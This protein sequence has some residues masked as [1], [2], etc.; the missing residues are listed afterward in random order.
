MSSEGD[1]LPVVRRVEA[2]YKQPQRDPRDRELSL[3]RLPPRFSRDRPR[4][5]PTSSRRRRRTRRGSSRVS[6]SPSR[7]RRRAACCGRDT[8]RCTWKVTDPDGDT[9]TYEVAFKPAGSGRWLPLRKGVRETFYSFDTTALPDGEYVFRADGVRRRVEP[10]GGRRP[11]SRDSS[12][13][14]DGQHAS[15]HPRACRAAATFSNSKRRMPPP[16]SSRP[17]TASTRR[18]GCASSRRTGSPTLR[19][20]RYGSSIDPKW[21]RG[22]PAHSRDRRRAKR[23]RGE[24]YAAVV[25][26]GR[27]AVCAPASRRL[28]SRVIHN[29]RQ[30]KKLFVLLLVVLRRRGAGQGDRGRSRDAARDSGPDGDSGAGPR[31]HR[32]DREA[33]RPWTAASCAGDSSAS[34]RR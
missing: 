21:Q 26:P 27:A 12:P 29:V 33:E 24:L 22:F 14:T 32:R 15:G 10:R 23:R 34:R 20:R 31:L 3:L 1:A 9:L 25:V 16:R 8:A 19:W 6:R 13:V 17:S 4:A 2:A 28:D 18:S 5:E 11:S 30:V 7:S